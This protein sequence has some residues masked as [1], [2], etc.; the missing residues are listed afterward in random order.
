MTAHDPTDA[1]DFGRNALPGYNGAL[2]TTGMALVDAAAPAALGDGQVEKALD[3]SLSVVMPAYRQEVSIAEDIRNV[4]RAV[5]AITDSY[6]IIVVV[7]GFVDATY[8]R[9]QAVASER[10]RVRVLGYTRN[11]GKGHAVRYGM[12]HAAGERIAFLDAGMDLDPSALARFSSIMDETGADIVVGSKRHPESVVRYPFLRRVYSAAYQVLVWLLFGLNV[13]DTQVGL[14]LFRREVIERVV[15]LLL[16]KRFAFDI[17]L[18]VVA[19]QMG[20]RHLVE[21][22]VTLT[23]GW[24]PSTIGLRSVFGMLWDTAAVFYRAHLLQYYRRQTRRN[25]AA[26]EGSATAELPLNGSRGL[27]SGR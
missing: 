26:P 12:Q 2:G 8:D 25:S 24:F 10:E 7:D 6:E 1:P 14:K 20:Y 11:G 27:A 9:A 17:E 15:P 21:A 13:R 3:V 19:A 4:E 5:R 16:V 18:L 23:H 22:P